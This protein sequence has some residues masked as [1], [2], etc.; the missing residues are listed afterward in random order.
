MNKLAAERDAVIE[1]MSKVASANGLPL[2]YPVAQKIAELHQYSP[3]LIMKTADDLSQYD[4]RIDHSADYRGRGMNALMT[5][6]I[7]AGVSGLGSAGLATLKGSPYAPEIGLLAG[8][9]GGLLG[10]G[11]GALHNPRQQYID[12][13]N[14][15]L[16]AHAEFMDSLN[17][18]RMSQKS[19]DAAADAMWN[20]MST[21]YPIDQS[22]GMVLM[23]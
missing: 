3:I 8:G 7:G 1:A 21:P 2:T 22:S 9:V 11:L 6:L 18:A 23:F 20:Q 4:P 13:R 14:A 17:A 16:Q 15:R 12:E 5:G 19:R 10:A